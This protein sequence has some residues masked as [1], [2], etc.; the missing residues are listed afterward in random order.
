VNRDEAKKILLLHR[1]GSADADDPQIAEALALA[2]QDAELARWLEQHCTQ[3]ELLR[4]K[5]RELEPPPGLKQQIISE[6]AASQKIISWRRPVVLAAAAL[7]MAL[8]PLALLWVQS[9]RPDTLAKYRARMVSAALRGYAMDL[10]T[11]DM[12][13]IRDYLAQRQSPSDYAL[14]VGLKKVAVAGCA[15]EK[16]QGANVALVCFRTGKPLPPGEQSDLWLFV[17]DRTSLKDVPVSNVP[18]LAR[19]NRLITATWTDGNKIYL[20]GV[21]GDEQAIRLF[22]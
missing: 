18:Q 7:V 5:F 22:L 10:E 14:P 19:V 8:I 17:V 9:S 1:P 12:S 20:L 3:Q 21:T 2:K 6:H 16:W 15:V 4:A 13:Q 11:N